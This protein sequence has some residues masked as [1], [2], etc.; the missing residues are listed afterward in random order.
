MTTV[1]QENVTFKGTL[2]NA[3]VLKNGGGLKTLILTDPLSAADRAQLDAFVT[4]MGGANPL[5]GPTAGKMQ[6]RFS[7]TPV[8]GTATGLSSVAA[9]TAAV[10]TVNV[11]GA[12]V[13]GTA[14]GLSSAVGTAGTQIV[15]F[16]PGKV[17]GDST[18]LFAG[19]A[20]TAGR[21]S[22]SWTG[23]VGA[24]ATGLAN[25]GTAYTATITVDGVGKAIS[26]V[27]SASQ[28]FTTLVAGIN[29]DL[30][31]SATATI[32]SPTELRVTSAT[33]G[34]SSTV[35]IVDGTLFAALTGVGTIQAAVAGVAAVPATTYTA[36]ITVDGVA[37][38]ISILGSAAQTFTTLVAEINTD[39]AAAATA[40]ISGGDIVVTS[41]TVGTTSKVRIVDGTLFAAVSDFFNVLPPSD[42]DGTIRTYSATVM[43]DGSKLKSI[44]VSGS[45]AQTYTTL[46]AAINTDLGVDAT[47]SL[48]GGNLIITSASTGAT[49]SVDIYDTGLFTG[50]TSFVGITTV[51]GVAPRIYRATITVNGVAKAIA[52]QGSAAQTFTTLVAEIN[53][54]L[55]GSA[56]AAISAGSII[57]TSATTGL[58]STVVGADSDLF[59]NVAGFVSL[60]SVAGATDMVDAMKLKRVGS[61]SLF[62]LFDVK[63]VGAKPAMP[64]VPAALPK[65]LDFTYF[66]GT[67]WKY[68]VDDTDVNP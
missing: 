12:K 3:A 53:T 32:H 23:L 19:T 24:S 62:D 34:A 22:I 57:V 41:A 31:A 16:Q 61:G 49:S 33:T 60:N 38:A 2:S 40:A 26:V 54:D 28:T 5:A 18:G 48:S 21:Q 64:A 51:P 56:T 8:G 11:G 63:V 20:A 17:G 52:V 37:K 35:A 9:A 10:A 15:N 65:T 58:A 55:G 59:R 47:A 13:G 1:T 50:L 39:L 7:T 27:G 4:E 66:N 43:V 6:V 68:L 42:G 67:V 14:T 29:T 45:A 44:G 46:L 30:G 25:N 36:T